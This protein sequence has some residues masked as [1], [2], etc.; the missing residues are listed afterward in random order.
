MNTEA[1][2]EGYQAY[3]KGAERVHCPYLSSPRRL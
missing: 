3:L 2:D 1:W